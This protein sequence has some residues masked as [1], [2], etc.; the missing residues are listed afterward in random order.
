MIVRIDGY[1]H[2]VKKDTG[3]GRTIVYCSVPASS[4]RGE[5]GFIPINAIWLNELSTFVCGNI[6]EAVTDSYLWNGELKN[7]IIGFDLVPE[8]E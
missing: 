8:Q 2:L 3:D 5:F 7:K 1:K 4:D 6:Y